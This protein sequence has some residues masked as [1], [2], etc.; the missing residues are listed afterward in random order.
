M[1]KD[2]E[3]EDEEEE[4][5]MAKT[6][7]LPVVEDEGTSNSASGGDGGDA[8]ESIALIYSGS[9]LYHCF[10]CRKV[11]SNR[12]SL[13]K[14]VKANISLTMC[15]PLCREDHTHQIIQEE[16]DE[17]DEAFEWYHSNEFDRYVMRFSSAKSFK[18]FVCTQR[19]NHQKG[20]KKTKKQFKCPARMIFRRGEVCMCEDFSEELC[21]S[22]KFRILVYGCVAHSHPMEQK[23]FRLSKL[24]KDRIRKYIERGM[25]V[26]EIVKQFGLPEADPNSRPVLKSDVYRIAK[27]SKL[28]GEIGSTPTE[29]VISESSEVNVHENI[30]IESLP[31]DHPQEQV[32]PETTESERMSFESQEQQTTLQIIHVD[33]TDHEFAK[34]LVEFREKA[35]KIDFI[36]TSP[37][38]NI[39]EKQKVMNSLRTLPIQEVEIPSIKCTKFSRAKRKKGLPS[40]FPGE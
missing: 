18:T 30:V 28:R 32:A 26:D 5:T 15:R 34:T 31:Y 6:D 33:I 29:N 16:F 36:L 17:M 13:R 40:L 22:S 2:M 39:E 8:P 37:D 10:K 4:D 24:T 25:R 19:A 3:E 38:F 14:H 20:S 12:P 9:P 21:K 11:F 27:A 23:N 1:D 35:Q 7:L